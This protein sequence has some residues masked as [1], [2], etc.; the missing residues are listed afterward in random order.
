MG[1]PAPIREKYRAAAT[2]EERARWGAAIVN[3]ADQI[4]RNAPPMPL[5]ATLLGH[6]RNVESMR[7][8][9]DIWRRVRLCPFREECGCTKWKC[10]DRGGERVGKDDCERC[11]KLPE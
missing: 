9:V 5:G 2:D 7:A 10:N 6:A 1:V 8:A 3:L 11:P 4:A